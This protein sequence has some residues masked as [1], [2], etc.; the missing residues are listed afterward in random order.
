MWK[1]FKIA[2][3]IDINV[4]HVSY[5]NIHNTVPEKLPDWKFHIGII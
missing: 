3:R 5:L 1:E 4:R 2:A